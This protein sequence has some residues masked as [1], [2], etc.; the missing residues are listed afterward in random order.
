M[1][2][3]PSPPPA[4]SNVVPMPTNWPG[5]MFQPKSWPQP[6]SCFSQLASLNACYDSIQM[7][8][9]ILSKVITDLVTNDPAVQQ[10]IVEAI[11][12]SGSNVPLIGVTNGSSAQPGQVGEV[13]TGTANMS[14]VA[15]NQT[16]NVAPM[17]LPPGDWDVQAYAEIAVLCDG[18]SFVTTFTPVVGQLG[19]WL[20][21]STTYSGIEVVSPVAQ[22]SIAVPTLLTFAV[23][24]NAVTAAGN[25][26]LNVLARRRR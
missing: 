18:A 21:T 20:F 4:P 8:E 5:P 6:P 9:Q 15:G 24:V 1:S 10:A 25:G 2:G 14:L 7:M 11:A 19:G 3:N 16:L 13:L 12:K 26:T 23:T 17:T 22:V